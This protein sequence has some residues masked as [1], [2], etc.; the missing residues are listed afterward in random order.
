MSAFRA[1]CAFLI[2]TS[3]V[4]AGVTTV[5]LAISAG[6]P[7]AADDAAAKTD[8]MPPVTL[9]SP[10]DGDDIPVTKPMFFWT[11]LPGAQHYDILIDDAKAGTADAADGPV[12]HWAATT[13][14]APGAH[15]WQV[16]GIPA[17]G[18]P[19]ASATSSFTI[20]ID[21]TW[22]DWAIGPFQRYARNPLLSPQGTGWESVNAFNPGVVCSDGIFHMLYRA[23][24][25]AWTSREGYAESKDGITFTSRPDPVINA[26]EPFERSYGCEDA[27]LFKYQGTY[28]AFYTGNVPKPHGPIAIC[29]ATST[30]CITWKKLGPVVPGTKNAA[31]VCDPTGTPVKINGKFVM[32]CGNS[33][34]LI[35]YSDDMLTWT[36]SA[37]IKI[38]LLPHWGG[39]FEP[40]VA[41]QDTASAH[42][43]NIVLLIAGTL[44]GRGKWFYAISEVLMT[45]KDPTTE[46]EQL[47]D[48]IM[49]PKEPYESG[50]NR[51]CLWTNCLIQKD[52]QW[53]MYYG[54]GDRFVALA[55][56]PV[57]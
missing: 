34:F 27:R 9:T 38:H 4:W 44:N 5:S 10:K 40:C 49:K 16:K 55:T 46:V 48:C 33:R 14:L 56:A 26:T 54:A 19:V 23:Q 45:A 2:R 8:A 20:T 41:V 11:A 51:N 28:Y 52:G 1:T 3:S 22:P 6:T 30:D 36:P 37:P 57:H 43:D 12:E 32:Y 35:S 15:H 39:P 47:D 29:E 50:Q 42:P 21:R 25:K 17:S 7:A 31:I 18:D 24:A 13:A 53:L